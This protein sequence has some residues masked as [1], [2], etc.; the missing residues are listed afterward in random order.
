DLSLCTMEMTNVVQWIEAGFKAGFLTEKET[1]LDISKLGSRPFFENLAHQIAFREGFGDILAEGLLR[2][3]EKLGPDARK[4]F[5][6][7]VSDVGSGATYS[8]REYLMNALLY[9]FE[10]RQPI[11]MLHEVS[12][13]IGQWVLN[14]DHPGATPVT[15]EVYR[16]AARV[17]W[18]HDQA[19]DLNNREGKAMAATR[20]IDRTYVKDS[21]LLCDSSWP[22]MVSWNTPDRVG[23]P[24][25]ESR[26][27]GAVT[28]IEID[29]PGLLKYGE[30][31]FNLQRA[32]LL[33]EGLTPKTDDVPE[34]FNFTDPVE[35]VFMNPKVVVP[36]PE[37]EVISRKG[38]ILDR[39]DYEFM[40][41]EFYELRGWDPETGM[42]RA[43]TLDRLDLSDLAEDLKKN[44]R[45]IS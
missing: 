7:E 35:T 34:E 23:D 13:I 10:P 17:F 40:R 29:E 6:N 2:A 25:L 33:R 37:E 18:N 44:G 8:G 43:N 39:E 16:K 3:G 30:R 45:V 21:L 22:M 11:A 14:L 31:I 26:V 24:T 28:G 4:L 41:R 27:F 15:A 19:W 42:Q 12:R 5:S 1:G 9:A 20:T 32:I 36:G 38:K